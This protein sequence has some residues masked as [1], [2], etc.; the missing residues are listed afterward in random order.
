VVIYDL[1]SGGASEFFEGL[2]KPVD[3]QGDLSDSD[4]LLR[5]IDQYQIKGVVHAAL[6]YGR[7]T[8]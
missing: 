4:Q 6:A 5:V 3:V 2:P 7:Q 8:L 1:Y